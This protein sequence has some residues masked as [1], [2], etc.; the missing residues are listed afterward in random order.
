MIVSVS[1]RTDIPSFYSEWFFNRLEEGFVLTQNPRNSEQIRQISLAAEDV[2]AFVFWTKNPAPMI[3]RLSELGGFMYYFQ[4]TITP[5]GSDIELNL[6]PKTPDTLDAFKKLSQI[7]GPDRVIWRYDPILIN[8]KYTAEYHARAFEK[9][10]KEL[11]GH[12]QR[13]IISFVE[14]DYRGAKNNADKLGLEVLSE[15]E[16]EKIAAVFAQIAHGNDLSI[17]SC[18]G[19]INLQK[20]GIQPARCID[21]DLISRLISRDLGAKKDK[22][23]RSECGCAASVDIG[24]YNTCLNGCL[25]CYANYNKGAVAAN[26][27][28]HNPLSPFLITP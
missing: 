16:Q 26:H 5:Y 23:Q 6:P 7:I 22:N 4:F 28:R 14:A 2:D 15:N 9:M 25:Y 3:S 1:R 21:G 13:V 8:L 12:T 19:K 27:A 20:Y 17:H 24:A 11:C 18:A 10:T